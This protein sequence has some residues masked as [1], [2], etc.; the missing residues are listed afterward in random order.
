MENV[1]ELIELERDVLTEGFCAG[2]AKVF[3]KF[4]SHPGVFCDMIKSET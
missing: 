3:I 4:R 2:C 1:V